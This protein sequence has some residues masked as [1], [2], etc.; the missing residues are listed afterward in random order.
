M[1]ENSSKKQDSKATARRSV[2]KK[3]VVGGGVAA[4]AKMMPDEWQKPV[5]ESVI[6]PAHAGTSPDNGM[7]TSPNSTFVVTEDDTQIV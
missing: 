3:M 7:N 6:L 2:L 5:V 4:T 1:T